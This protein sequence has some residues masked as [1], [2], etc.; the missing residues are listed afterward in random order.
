MEGLEVL[1]EHTKSELKIPEDN[2]ETRIHYELIDKGSCGPSVLA[3]ITHEEVSTIIDNWDNYRGFA[4][5]KEIRN[6]LK[7][8]G[9][10]TK[11]RQGGKSKEFPIPRT[12]LAII[13]IQWLNDGKEWEAFMEATKHTHYVLMKRV[14]CA[15]WIFCNE[16]GWFKLRS[17][18]A[19]NYLR[20]GY[21]SSYLEL[22]KRVK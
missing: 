6:E 9:Y 5:V 17:E 16:S 2:E 7:K 22:I 15:W 14:L 4:P 11:F 19:R 12:D 8:Y 1:T 13:R 21:V 3:V 10:E 18:Q 20:N